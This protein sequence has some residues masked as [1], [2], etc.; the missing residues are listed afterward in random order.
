M[1][2]VLTDIGEET[3]NQIRQQGLEAVFKKLDVTDEKAWD[4]LF[5]DLI[6]E[7]K[8]IDILVNNAGIDI[9]NTI[10]DTSIEDFDRVFRVN[11][12]GPFLGMRGAIKQM[13]R[14]G[15]G[16][17]V[18]ISSMSSKIVAPTATV[19]CPS[20]AAVASLTKVAAAH[21]GL[22]DY[23]IRI[24]SVHPGF[25]ETELICGG[26]N[27]VIEN[28]L[29]KTMIQSIPLKRIS[30]P[31]EIANVVL[32]LASAESSYMTGAEIFVDGGKTL[33]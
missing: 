31:E 1:T 8:R 16:T 29:V 2:D 19:Y 5:N 22:S 12:I 13:K 21:C 6:K 26:D 23:N 10:E 32:F 20:K 25:T 27:P 3:A 33:M 28:P 17:I 9:Q 4:T 14:T 15:G 30:Q 7:F 18:N 24:N 11:L